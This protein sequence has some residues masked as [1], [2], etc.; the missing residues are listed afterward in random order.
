[1]AITDSGIN[2]L[3]LGLIR[4]ANQLPHPSIGGFIY[5]SVRLSRTAAVID[6]RNRPKKTPQSEEGA[7]WGNLQL[8]HVYKLPCCPGRCLYTAHT[9]VKRKSLE[10]AGAVAENIETNPYT[11]PRYW[12]KRLYPAYFSVKKSPQAWISGGK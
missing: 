5:D 1:M 9:L 7:F 6:L 11:L 10:V 2:H 3:L 8:F 12:Q 4:T